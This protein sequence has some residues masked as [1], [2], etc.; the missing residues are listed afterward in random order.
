MSVLHFS[1]RY[2]YEGSQAECGAWQKTRFTDYHYTHDMEKF[3]RIAV[4][5][6]PVRRVCKKCLKHVERID[7]SN[8]R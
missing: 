1:H 5:A 7:R 2:D 6:D 3:K 4:S 8:A